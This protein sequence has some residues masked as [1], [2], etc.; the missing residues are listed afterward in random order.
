MNVKFGKI[1][2]GRTVRPG[3]TEDQRP[4]EQARHALD[5][6]ARLDHLRPHRLGA[7]EGEQPA[8]QHG[9]AGRALGGIV[10]VAQRLIGV[11]VEAALRAVIDP[12]LAAEQRIAYAQQRD[13]DGLPDRFRA[14]TERNKTQIGER[15]D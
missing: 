13:F 10:D 6:R 15:R 7:R 12:A 3:K 1:L 2:T 11:R 5:Q 9:G 8:G 4:V 14:V